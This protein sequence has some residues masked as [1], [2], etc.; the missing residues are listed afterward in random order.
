MVYPLLPA[1]V[2]GTLGGGAALLGLLDGAAD[3]TS[4]VLKVVSGGWPTGPR[5][6][7]PLILVGYATAVLVRPLIAVAGAAWQVVG[8]RVIDRVGR[9]SG[10]RRATRSSP[11]SRRPS[12][13]AARSASTAA[14]DH[15]GAVIGSLA[16]WYLLSRGAEVRRVIGWSVVP[17]LVAFVVL[18]A[19]LRVATASPAAAA[20]PRRP[21]TSRIARGR[22]VL[23]AGA[24]AHRR[25]PSS[26]CPR[27]CSCSG[28]RTRRG[29]GIGAAGLGRPSRGAERELVSGRLASD[30]LGRAPRWRPAAW[31]SPPWSSRWALTL[32]PAVRSRHLPGARPGRRPHRVRRAG[33]GGPPGP[34][35]D[36][37]GL[38]RCI[39]R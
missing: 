39:M 23:G 20:R 25:S 14:A 5:W 3:L 4:A 18:A 21:A 16:A 32:G 12:F 11:G 36:R 31:S 7:R 6:R 13:G 15:F 8:F 2:T 30:R 1:F 22:R 27:R 24:G 17:G 29:R 19:V 35:A 37:A 34:G 38:R 28:C 33:P 9:E 10:R 26:G